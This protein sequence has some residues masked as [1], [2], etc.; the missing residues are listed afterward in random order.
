MNLLKKLS[1]KCLA[2]LLAAATI[3]SGVPSTAVY[4]APE[5]YKAAETSA[6]VQR[7]DAAAVSRA[8]AAV[9]KARR[10]G[11]AEDIKTAW[12]L[13]AALSPI[14]RLKLYVELTKDYYYKNYRNKGFKYFNAE[15][16]LEANE[17]VRL[18]ARMYSPD[19]M[20]AYALKHYLEQGIFEGRSSGTGFDPMVAIIAKPEILFDIVFSPDKEIPDLIHA[21]FIRVTGKTTTD[22]YQV[23]RD[24]L[25][26]IDKS[27][28]NAVTDG[29]GLIP[30]DNAGNDDDD[31]DD[32]ES[33]NAGNEDNEYND[34]D[35]YD[36]DDDFRVP[37]YVNNKS[38]D[39]DPYVLYRDSYENALFSFTSYNPFDDR[40]SNKV[41]NV[42]FMGE[43]Y[44]RAK[45]LSQ[46][47]KYTLMLYFCGTNL[48]E[49][50][51]NRSVSGELVSLMQADMSNVNVILCVGGTVSYGN[52]LMNR[53]SAD[54]S[55]YGAS[56]LRSGIYYLNPDALSSIRDRLMRVDTDKGDAMYQLAG[57][58]A[59][60]DLSQGLHFDDI[61]TPDSFIQLVSTS[62]V[63][64]ADPSFLAGFI[65]LSTNLFPAE[66]YGLTLSDHGGGLEGGVIYTDSM[67]SGST[68]FEENWLTVYKLESALAST[69][70]YRDRSVSSDGKLGVIYY[71]ACLMGSTGQAYNTK[72]YYRYMVASEECSSGHTSYRYLVTGLNDDVA[73]GRSD[74]EIAIHFAE[75]Y[76]EYPKTHHGFDGV[77]VGS[78]AVFSS[79]DMEDMGDNINDLA[80]ELSRI[81]GTDDYAGRGLKNDVF[82]AIRKASLSCYPTNAADDDEY[83]GHFLDKTRFVD[84]GELL[85][86][87]KYNLNKVSRNNYNSDD[88]KELE[89]L[90]S[91]L[92]RTLNSGF[93]VFLSMYN[94]DIGGIYK[95]AEDSAVPLNYTMDV[96][97]D[98]WT[99]IRA[100]K[101]GIRDYLYGSSIYMPLRESV[102]DFKDSDY[103]KYYK[104]TDLND[105]VDFID[106]YLTYFN[107]ENGYAGKISA[108]KEELYDLSKS[109]NINK[110]VKQVHDPDN[111]YL[112]K[113]IDE[114]GDTR[115]YL[116]FKIADSYE[117]A[118]LQTP[119]DS[120]GNPMLDLLET[121]YSIMMAAVHKQRFK[122]AD[123]A[124]GS[125]GVLEVDMI[126][127]EAPVAP[128][129]FALDSNTLSFDVTDPAK[130]IIEGISLEGKTWDG[131]VGES[132]W[133]FVLKSYLEFDSDA[134]DKALGVLFGSYDKDI[135]TLTVMGGTKVKSSDDPIEECIHFFKKDS[136]GYYDY[137]GSV[138]DN[139][140][141]ARNEYERINRDDTIAIAAYHYVLQEDENG[142]LTKKTLEFIDG[143]GFGYFAVDENNIPYLDTDI[144]VAEKT[145]DGKYNGAATG[146]VIDLTGSRGSG[147]HDHY[148]E[149]GDIGQHERSDTH[150]GNG[151][152]A[153]VDIARAGGNV[154]DSIG[155]YIVEDYANYGDTDTAAKAEP[156]E[157]V[158][159]AGG[160]NTDAAVETEDT[161]DNEVSG[162]VAGSMPEG[163]QYLAEGQESGS[164]SAPVA[165]D[166][167]DV[168]VSAPAGDSAEGA[169]PSPEGEPAQVSDP[170]QESG[171]AE[172][173]G[174]QEEPQ[175]DDPSSDDESIDDSDNEDPGD[176]SNDDSDD[177]SD[178]E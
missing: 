35:Y 143:I 127:A 165:D 68:V 122:A 174:G 116:S 164:D 142:N 74:R 49:D 88:I 79:E 84:I 22:S 177:E 117:E 86:H 50:E 9:N 64:M 101:D 69:D 136:E 5:T 52:S 92:D 169:E 141:N 90:M 102:S 135:Q 47:K 128:F 157:T 40:N 25:I 149:V 103:Y 126:C 138:R 121:Q 119:A 38:I 7:S 144:K 98:I 111:S 96:E 20:F 153:E 167:S 32:D 23:L 46:G 163:A 95:Y 158:N 8:V 114:N 97:R 14:D 12:E 72:D 156:E 83:Y 151:P 110:L 172:D 19:D 82:M 109:D 57:T 1:S 118:G 87:V 59:G 152:L 160:V 120:T 94:T 66:N 29:S 71:N 16:Y 112:R 173:E 36:D 2:G 31:D 61:I 80:R 58:K 13:I 17:D 130:S 123:S 115:S 28:D 34:D 54:G 104:D 37:H 178:G 131:G 129:A 77:Y 93:L 11:S 168:V 33:D 137:C 108:L 48:E 154:I 26:V 60:T 125:T 39:I 155:R 85:T 3:I 134:K 73:E 140:N 62:A 106:N 150:V 42:R 63:D 45:E 10:T 55:T 99:D 133:Q 161:T 170:S 162:D 51:Y 56:N 146:Y 147:E 124:D 43:N 89:R 105:Y 27:V 15:K 148:S 159:S 75:V 44:R 175:A 81:L 113:V 4:A 171:P 67:N 70:L 132:D 18:A 78:I 166:P 30:F 24:S 65:N 53:D 21:S 139:Y 76:G 6:N 100:D 41:V 176:E 107:D 91:K 145:E